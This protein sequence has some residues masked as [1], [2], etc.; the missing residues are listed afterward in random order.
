M[1]CNRETASPAEQNLAEQLTARK[2]GAVRAKAR[3]PA[4]PH[5]CSQLRWLLVECRMAPFIH[6]AVTK[7][8]SIQFRIRGRRAHHE[9]KTSGDCL[10]AC[11]PV[12]GRIRLVFLL[13]VTCR[14]K[15]LT[16]IGSRTR[17]LASPLLS[18]R[19]TR[20]LATSTSLWRN[21]PEEVTRPRPRPSRGA[22]TSG[23]QP[24]EREAELASELA[25]L[26][27]KVEKQDEMLR[28]IVAAVEGGRSLQ[29]RGGVD[30]QEGSR[31]R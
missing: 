24:H 29:T 8:S 18:S 6:I 25:E 9:S 1:L 12:R 31:S 19:R 14:G 28:R 2:P 15:R 30:S 21:A 3:N 27:A 20:D 16:D 5:C 23:S 17:S 13:V 11:R 4:L 10:Q 26:R 22:S 7:S